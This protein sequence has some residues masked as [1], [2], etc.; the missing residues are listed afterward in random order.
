[1][2][3]AEGGVFGELVEDFEEEADAE[4]GTDGLVCEEEVAAEASVGTEFEA[5]DDGCL[6]GG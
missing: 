5:T 1:M 4:V 6:G 2:D 3:V